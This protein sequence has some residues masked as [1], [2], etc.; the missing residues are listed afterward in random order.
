M[1]SKAIYLPYGG[2]DSS[3]SQFIPDATVRGD[4]FFSGG[5]AGYDEQGALPAE[6]VEQGERIY[7]RLR[8]ALAEANFTADEVGHLFIW[9]LERHPVIGGKV[10]WINRYWEE[11]F[12][13]MLDRPA[14]HV[15]GRPLDHGIHYRIEILAVRGQ[16]R[17]CYEV[18]DNVYHLGGSSSPRYMPFGV[19]IGKYFFTGPTYG[20]Y[21]ATRRMGETATKQ[22][23]LCTE[24]NERFYAMAGHSKDNLG[25]LWV[26]YHDD[27]AKAAALQQ[28][29]ISFPDPADRPSI[30]YLKSRL[31]FWDEVQAQFLIQYDNVGVGGER[32]RVV[33]VPGVAV[34]GGAEQSIPAAVAMGNVLFGSPIVG[35]GNRQQQLREAL[36]GAQ[37]S[38]EAGGFAWCDVGQIYVWLRDM[39]DRDAVDSIWAEEFPDPNLRPV[40]HVIQ[41]PE[42]PAGT[43]V[44]VEVTAAR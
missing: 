19:A 34:L 17:T 18:H 21:A 15:L 30:H 7:A 38:V 44:A 23:A 40:R 26:W 42:L 4:L 16:R 14:R 32:R 43:D 9:A 35:R 12:P 28:T 5:L 2:H 22:A 10:A 36:Q 41:A 27:D 33:H 6:N 3:R 8:Q 13:V 39:N 37:A 20:M 25:R 1:N 11:M 31:P 24:L 29:E